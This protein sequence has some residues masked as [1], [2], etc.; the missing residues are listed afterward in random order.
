MNH[1]EALHRLL[2]HPL[3]QAVR[4]AAQRRGQSVMLVGGAVRDVLLGRPP[5]TLS[6]FDFATDA[7]A[8]GLARHLA[9][10]LHGD[11]YLLDSARGTARVLTRS[12][13]SLVTLDFAL[14]RGPTWTD[15]L[16]ARDFSINAIGI[17]LDTAQWLDPL[18]GVSDLA[19][20]ALRL[21]DPSAIH[22]DPVRALRAVRLAH[23]LEL[24]IDPA[25]LQALPQARDRLHLSSTERQ[26]D[27]LFAILDLPRASA[28]LREADA[29]GLLA[30]VLPEV[31]PMRAHP[32]PE[33]HRFNV[34]EHTWH[35]LAHLDTLIQAIERA[36][37]PDWLDHGSALR[38]MLH[39]PLPDRRTQRALMRFA[40]LLHDCAKPI[41]AAE[42][43][44]AFAFANHE[45][46]SAQLTARRA[47]ALRLSRAEVAWAQTFVAHHAR[48]NHLAQ[49]A[50]TV[51][52]RELYRLFHDVGDVLPALAL[53]AVADCWGKRG[54]QTTQSD[55]D[56]SQ[57][58]ASRLI[59]TYYT[60]FAPDVLPPPLID[61]HDL[62]QMG[63]APGP[64]LGALLE[65]VREAQLCDALHTR[66]EALEWARSHLGR[67]SPPESSGE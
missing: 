38:A 54:S 11:F 32:Q 21:A 61:G 63:M 33:P 49:H 66:A 12:Q 30:A 45:Q 37:P 6:D 67:S 18:G 7:D 59:Q 8:A 65:Q 60:R 20:R 4:Q 55:C 27:E 41:L 50:A 17:A 23:Q 35:V 2:G 22:D 14:R 39:S 53:F 48:P 42:R 1:E 43:G 51:T 13:G 29:L 52:L 58:L 46:R 47:R 34:L 62:L 36:S 5:D 40:A 24:H 9:E 10:A 57:A 15:D 19:E 64:A 31:E 44:Q 56:R 25:L 28:A 26:R 3:V 16:R